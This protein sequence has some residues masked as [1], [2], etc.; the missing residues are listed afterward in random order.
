MDG[1]DVDS[2]A[3]AL[4]VLGLNC[5][6]C[7]RGSSGSAQAGKQ[8]STHEGQR[9]VHVRGVYGPRLGVLTCIFAATAAVPYLVSQVWTTGKYSREFFNRSGELRHIKKL[10]FWD[11]EGVLLDKYKL[12]AQEVRVQC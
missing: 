12:P 10:R 5:R 6:G 2:C 9:S 1:S 4:H 3:S 11:L 8:E 7:V